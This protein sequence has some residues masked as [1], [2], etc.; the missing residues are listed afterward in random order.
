MPVASV[1]PRNDALSEAAS[2][3]QTTNGTGRT[4]CCHSQTTVA[5]GKTSPVPVLDP[6]LA[7]PSNLERILRVEAARVRVR[8]SMHVVVVVDGLRTV[9]RAHDCVQLA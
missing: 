9:P 7:H 2:M 4:D 5:L 8:R 3:A 6:I 1:G